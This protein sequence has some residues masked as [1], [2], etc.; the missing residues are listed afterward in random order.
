[1]FWR[2]CWYATVVAGVVLGQ[3][4]AT[5]LPASPSPDGVRAPVALGRAVTVITGERHRMYEPEV[6]FLEF[7]NSATK[8][9]YSVQ[10]NSDDRHFVLALAPGEYELSRVQ[11][12]EG[13]FLSMADL[14]MIFTIGS[15]SVT[16]L[17]TWRFGVDSPRYGRMVAVSM[18][19]D[20]EDRMDAHEY[21]NA[22]YPQWGEQPI[23]E[24]LPQPAAMEARLY[25][26][27]PYPR[28]PR[29]FRRHLW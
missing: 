28:Y 16:H 7:V 19:L 29:Y 26:V 22:Q 20:E 1:M 21:V 13:P 10:L 23:A 4:C 27:M 15:D 9:R 8:D 3:G 6:R 2:S 11:I 25:E 24:V 18:V 17:G 5:S 14:S 12:S